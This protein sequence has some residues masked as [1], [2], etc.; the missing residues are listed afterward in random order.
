MWMGNIPGWS[1][2]ISLCVGNKEGT[3]QEL[4]MEPDD[5]DDVKRVLRSADYVTHVANVANN[6]TTLLTSRL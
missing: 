2:R 3:R 6:V 5:D 4:Q 1:V